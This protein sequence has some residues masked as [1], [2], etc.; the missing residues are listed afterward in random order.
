EYLA[1][2]AC[3]VVLVAD[4]EKQTIDRAGRVVETTTTVHGVP[5]PWAGEDWDWQLAPPLYM[6]QE[7]GYRLRVRGAIKA[8]SG[9]E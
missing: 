9:R 8:A 6:Q 4:F 1:R 2:F 5:L 7:T 3:P